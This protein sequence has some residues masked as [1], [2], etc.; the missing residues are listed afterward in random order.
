MRNPKN[1]SGVVMVAMTAGAGCVWRTF[2]PGAGV[3]NAQNSGASSNAR[4]AA[5]VG[6]GTNLR[7][8]A[9]SG[10]EWRQ[11]VVWKM[12]LSLAI[13]NAARLDGGAGSIILLLR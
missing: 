9:S 13:G 4:R 1:F 11:G 5:A 3:V 10:T 7:I 2:W 12:G 6:A 8:G